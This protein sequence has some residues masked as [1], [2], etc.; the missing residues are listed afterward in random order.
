[1]SALRA[2]R[3]AEH[4]A[5]G[6]GFVDFRQRE[7]FTRFLTPAPFQAGRKAQNRHIQEAADQQAESEGQGNEQDRIGLQHRQHQMA[8]ASLNTGRYMPMTIEPTTPPMTIITIG[9]IRL[10]SASTALFTSCS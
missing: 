7:N 2:G 4:Q 3:T 6:F 5:R 10:D 1:M 9:S 8:A